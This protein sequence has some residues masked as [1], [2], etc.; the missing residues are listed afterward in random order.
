MRAGPLVEPSA[1]FRER[2]VMEEAVR[3]LVAEGV[4]AQSIRIVE[5]ADDEG[6][7]PIPTTPGRTGFVLLGLTIGEGTGALMALA[8]LYILGDLRVLPLALIVQRT[9]GGAV[10]GAL[11]GALLGVLVWS[12]HRGA[13]R[14]T[15]VRSGDFLVRVKPSSEEAAEGVRVSLALH[16]G[17]IVGS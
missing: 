16:G 6:G 8:E 4:R 14:P 2:G 9:A 7:E 3:S 1:V 17:E 5:T 10:I 11:I 15:P 13:R 12:V